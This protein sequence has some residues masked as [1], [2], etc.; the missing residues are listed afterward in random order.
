[1]TSCADVWRSSSTRPDGSPLLVSKG[2]P[3]AILTRSTRVRSHDALEPLDDQ[4][5]A[6]I[7]DLF[8]AAERDGYRT[9][10]V[11]TRTDIPAT[12]L[13]PQAEAE[14][15]FEGLLLFDDPPKA[16]IETTLADLTR[17]GV[18]LKVVTGDS[19]VVARAV[20]E[21]VG[22]VVEDVLTGDQIRSMTRPAFAARAGRTTI[23]AR[24]DP[25]QKL[26]VIR[27][28]Q[29]RGS[30]VGYLGDGI[31]DAPSLHVADVG[32]SV[33]NGTDVARAAA[34]IVLL[35]PSLAAIAQGVRE[36][37]RTFANTLKYVRMGISSNFGNMLSMAG[38]AIFLPF[39]PMLP[40]QILLNNL[41]YDASQTA[42]PTDNIDPETEG[43]PA[44]WEIGGIERFMLVF[45]P[46][47]SIFDYLT[48]WLLLSVLDAGEAEFHTGWFVESLATQVLV[49]FAI[50]TRRSPFWK[51]RPSRPLTAAALTAVGVA[52][53][54]PVSP[55]AATLGF[56]PLPA[57]FWAALAAF[58]VAYLA[59]VE[60]VKHWLYAR[61][62]RRRRPVT[63]SGGISA[64]A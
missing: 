25:D 33:D 39:L 58:V 9:I 2:A 62:D 7:T 24:V 38:A 63:G 53:V 64:R 5:H 41:I 32:I 57:P 11:G 13:D 23:F 28:L 19:E 55:F 48:F 47:S 30:V 27:A 36:G 50:R 20:A 61:E 54:L 52:I 31:N 4:R 29:E 56:A 18:A 22:L 45:G 46:L 16:N 6:Q 43:E 49:I 14:L 34:D 1:M 26:R 15:V 60:V 51:S 3:E 40:S 44:R 8:T 10:A 42:I 37:R 12:N 17:L 21:Q 59:I 35:Q